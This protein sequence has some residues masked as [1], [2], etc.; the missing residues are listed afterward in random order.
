MT[1]YKKNNRFENRFPP[2][3]EIL[4]LFLF[5][6]KVP[7]I[8]KLIDVNDNAPVFEKSLYE[9][10]LAPNLREF[11]APAFIRANDIDAEEPN[12]IVRYELI[13][14][15]YENKFVLDKITG[16]T[17]GKCGSKWRNSQ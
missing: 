8:I 14:G 9:F 12:N 3:N 17:C 5:P 16:K 6:E 10:I 4:I 13:N 1:E 11:T 2:S 15:N 7:L